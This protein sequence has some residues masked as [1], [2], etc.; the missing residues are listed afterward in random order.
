MEIELRV[1]ERHLLVIVAVNSFLLLL[2]VVE[3]EVVFGF[4]ADCL[5]SRLVAANFIFL[6]TILTRTYPLDMNFQ[7]SSPNFDLCAH[8]T[9][10]RKIRQVFH[11]YVT[12]MP[13]QLL[14]MTWI[15]P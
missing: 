13:P 15:E 3:I 5:I 2:L 7:A 1:S 8:F 10:G 9:P 4:A 12:L 14:E 6:C 11:P